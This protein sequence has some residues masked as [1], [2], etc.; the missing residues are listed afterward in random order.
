MNRRLSTLMLLVAVASTACLA[1]PPGLPKSNLETP[2]VGY[3]SPTPAAAPTLVTPANPGCYYNWATQDL[4]ALSEQVDAA[5][6]RLGP[7]VTGGAYAFGEDCIAADGSRT[8][9]AM[10]TDFR[11]RIRVDDLKDEGLLGTWIAKVMGAINTLP[12]ESVAGPRPG[13]VEF[14]FFTEKSDSLRLIVD[15]SK[16]REQGVGIQGAQLFRLFHPPP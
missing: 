4:P 15:I 7:A 12:A 3:A 13:R 2:L 10:E 1:R 11:A 9:S 6:G 8:F 16:Y 14:E 5:F